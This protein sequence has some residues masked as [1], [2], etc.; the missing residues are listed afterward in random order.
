[1]LHGWVH[2]N[3]FL[4]MLDDTITFIIKVNVNKTRKF[5][6]YFL[7]Q[8]QSFLYNFIGCLLPS[9]TSPNI[10]WLLNSI[11]KTIWLIILAVLLLLVRKTVFGFMQ[12]FILIFSFVMT[13]LSK[14]TKAFRFKRLMQDVGGTICRKCAK[15]SKEV[16]YYNELSFI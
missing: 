13:S 9:K 12:I 10:G 5:L 1:M 2:I 11:S 3:L 8:Q 15:M 6:T 4:C 7:L 16:S 14:D